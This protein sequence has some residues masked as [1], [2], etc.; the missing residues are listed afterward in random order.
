MTTECLVLPFEIADGPANMAMDE[1]LLDDVAQDP[2]HA[3]LRTYG[4]SAPTLSLGYFQR[5]GD[6]EADL[7]LGLGD[8]SYAGPGSEPEF[9]ELVEVISVTPAIAPMARS[10][11]VATVAAMVSGLAPGS[12]AEIEMVG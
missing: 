5:V 6:A 2:M 12:E 1:A 4:W 8:F 9:C 11:G 7:F 3:V 10:S